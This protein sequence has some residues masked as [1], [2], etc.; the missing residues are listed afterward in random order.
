MKDEVARMKIAGL[1]K[2]VERLSKAIMEICPHTE[3][4]VT[5]YNA[6]LI[7]R[8]CGKTLKKYYDNNK[9][10]ADLEKFGEIE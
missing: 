9:M 10:I 7:C 8:N 6:R 1:Q 2:E 4:G 5:M 3:K